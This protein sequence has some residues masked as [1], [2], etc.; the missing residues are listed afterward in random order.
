MG[1]REGMPGKTGRQAEISLKGEA[2]DHKKR[3]F[4]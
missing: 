2:S 3:K 4:W 1:Y